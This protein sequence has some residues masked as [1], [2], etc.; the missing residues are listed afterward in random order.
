MIRFGVKGTKVMK[1]II[2]CLILIIAYLTQGFTAFVYAE[3]VSGSS[4]TEDANYLAFKWLDMTTPEM[5]KLY[6][7]SHVTRGQFAY[8]LAGIL[9]YR[10]ATVTNSN[11]VD[12]QDTV[13]EGAVDFL[14]RNNIMPTMPVNRFNP[15]DP[16][17]Y[18]EMLTAI[19]TALGYMNL[20]NGTADIDSFVEKTATKIELTKGINARYDAS[21][22]ASETFKLLKRAAL[23]S[24]CEVD[25]VSK[26]TVYYTNKTGK[27]LIYTYSNI[28]YSEGLVT[29][30][31][32]TAIRGE[33]VIYNNAQIGD[34][35]VSTGKFRDIEKLLGRRVEFFYEDEGSVGILRYAHA[36]E[37]KNNVI[38]INADKLDP[39]D[40]DFS[41]NCIIYEKNRRSERL[42]ISL[43]ADFIYNGIRLD[44][45]TANN[46]AI[47]Q[48][49]ITAVDNDK[50]GHYDVIDI[51]EYED[52][53]LRGKSDNI[54]QL[55]G[56][57]LNIDNYSIVRMFN[58]AGEPIN[59][60]SELNMSAVIS[61]FT[62]KDNRSC[63]E[64]VESLASV[65][66]TVVSTGTEDDKPIYNTKDNT[67]YLSET[68]RKSII[69][70]VPGMEYPITGK[71][72]VFKLNFENR[73]V[74]ITELY[75][76][77]WQIA[78]CVGVYEI[79]N[80]SR[81]P[82]DGIMIKLVMPDNS[83]FEPF[84][85]KKVRIN[86]DRII[87]NDLMHGSNK[88]YCF[89]DENKKPIRQPVHIKISADGEITDIE[90][91]VDR[92]D[93]EYGYDKN[94]FSKDAYFSSGGYKAGSHHGIGMYTIR[95]TGT[96]I[97][98]PHL[99]ESDNGRT[100]DVE[101]KA[102]SNVAEGQMTECYIYDLDESY[103]CDILV[104]KNNDESLEDTTTVALVEKVKEVYDED[105][106]DERSLL[107][108]LYTQN[109]DEL[110]L[111]ERKAGI[112]PKDIKA[113]D[114]YKIAY[115][116]DI[117][118]AAE[119]IVSLADDPEPFASGTVVNQKWADIFGYVYSAC[120][121]SVT[122]IKP[123]GYSATPQ[124]LIGTALKGGVTALVYDLRTKKA[125][126]GSWEDMITSNVPDV[127]GDII[128][129]THSTKVYIYRR[130]D[131]A[132]GVVILKR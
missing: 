95:T 71:A 30:N 36:L 1:R 110:N 20:K 24:V 115:T 76:G 45:P 63:I 113:G 27:T 99:G 109:G 14:V 85:A 100:D 83:E 42:K 75:D 68:F 101:F 80:D 61:I 129:D 26:N 49:T 65:S 28:S 9:G 102:V 37:N 47:G 90:T 79:T 93:S 12:V 33:E 112:L 60:I 87:S 78:Y 32:I 127:N 126:V 132:N 51:R 91:P 81:L 67:Y 72:Y 74:S 94:V 13:Y 39:E 54:L 48:G 111:K 123:E 55:N 130:W 103:V 56:K 69:D 25:N 118:S 41:T 3:E 31:G 89:F 92:T 2:V 34:I 119:K 82:D 44:I 46:L 58:A 108:H 121:D 77:Q 53:I 50:D 10:P 11:I 124:K 66:D 16:I 62:S 122:V 73:I 131:Y 104:Y 4:I 64:I 107:V 96:V 117:L 15:K 52:Y 19:V 22:F 21:P 18:K 29:Q 7:D 97:E 106:D 114:V 59:D 5:D 17:L 57:S 125:Y 43:N 88:Y 128:I 86:G 23:T 84:F 38:T 6:S 120:P 35:Q 116:G 70:G 105:A 8:V 40:K 98:D